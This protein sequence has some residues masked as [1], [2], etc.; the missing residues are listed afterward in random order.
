MGGVG[1]PAPSAVRPEP[2]PEP[3]PDLGDIETP[4][5]TEE[6]IAEMVAMIAGKYDHAILALSAAVECVQH[7][8]DGIINARDHAAGQRARFLRLT[9]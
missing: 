3:E 6:L 7:A 1:R 5:F 8:A 2:E 9:R 4:V